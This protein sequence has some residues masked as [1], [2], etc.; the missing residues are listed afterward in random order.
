MQNKW[1]VITS[2]IVISF[3]VVFIGFFYYSKESSSL[4]TIQKREIQTIA[5]LKIDQIIHWR[6]EKIGDARVISQSPYFSRGVQTWL[7]HRLDTSLQNQLRRGLR[8]Y[9]AQFGF[10]DIL[11][12]SRKED[13][14]ISLDSSM[15]ELDRETIH[16][17]KEAVKYHDVT[18]SDCYYCPK[19]RKIHYDIIAPIRDVKNQVITVMIFRADPITNLFPLIGSLSIQ[20]RIAE[21][22]IVQR[23]GDSVLF[24]NHRRFGQDDAF[25]FINPSKKSNNDVVEF[26]QTDKGF[27]NGYDYRGVEVIAYLTTVPEMRWILI[28]KVDHAELNHQLFN[29]AAISGVILIIFLLLVGAVFAVYYRTHQK[30]TYK[31]LFQKERELRVYHEEFRTILY[32]VSDGVVTTDLNGRVKIMNHSAAKLTGWNEAEAK[33]KHVNEVFTI[34]REDT[35][36]IVECPITNILQ[37]DT[38]ANPT[39]NQLLLSKDGREIPIIESGAPIRDELGEVE[40]AVL[41][42]HD[43]TLEYRAERRLHQSEEKYRKAFITSPDAININRLEDGMYVSIN[44]GFTDILGYTQ[45]DVIGKTS[46]ELNIWETRDDRTTFVEAL[47]K[48]GVVQNIVARL[49]GKEN[50]IIYGMM[51]ASIVELGEVKHILSI[52]RDITEFKRVEGAMRE[53]EKKYRNM[54]TNNPQPMWIYD[55][56]TLDFLEVNDAAINHYG[57]SKEEFLSMTIADIRP[58]EDVDA[59]TRY[60]KRIAKVQN[61]SGEWFHRKK[62]GK[63]IS[64]EVVSHSITYRAR[65]ARH[66]IINDITERKQTENALHVSEERFRSLVEIAPLGIAVYQEG[67][68]VY[69]NPAGVKMFG[70]AHKQNLLG[71]PIL[72]FVHP[73]DLETVIKRMGLIAGGLV[74]D[75]VEEKFVRLDGSPFDAEVVALATTFND[76]P[77]GQVIVRD[78]TE[79]KR[80]EEEILMFKLGIERSTD[81]IFITNSEGAITY[82]NKSFENVYGYTQ[83]EIVGRTPRII[84]SGILTL[85]IYQRFWSTLM[86][87]GIVAGEIIN[88]TKDGRLLTIDG[89]NN[90][91]MDATG[92]IVG[93]LGV[94]R[95]ISERKRAENALR[96]SEE[97]LRQIADNVNEVFWIVDLHTQTF[98]FVNKAFESIWGI[99][100]EGL[101]HDPYIW[102]KVIHPLDRH[103]VRNFVSGDS[104]VNNEFRII[105]PDASVRWIHTKSFPVYDEK[106][107]IFRIAGIASD[108]TEIKNASDQLEQQ[109]LKLA[110]VEKM[111]SLGRVVAGV[112]HEINNPNNAISLSTALLHQMVNTI[113]PLVDEFRK[114]HG[115]FQIGFLDY[116]EYRTHVDKLFK[117]IEDGSRQIKKIVNDLKDYARHEALLEDTIVDVHQSINGAITLMD[118]MI[119]EKTRSFTQN[120]ADAQLLILGQPHRLDQVFINL[121]HNACDA[122]TDPEQGITITTELCGADQLKVCV[123]DQG[124]GISSEDLA[125]VT[126]PFFSTKLDSGGTGLGLS[127]TAGIVKDFAGEMFIESELGKGSTF[128][129]V[130]PRYNH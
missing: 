75:S 57:Y 4:H 34:I 28:T 109:K 5:L 26:V 99:P 118:Y 53:S 25:L 9:K 104:P 32:S 130:F 91:I 67:R 123:S 21:T 10:Q 106:G 127:V 2:A 38:V 58:N 60:V 111:S 51:S 112:A 48:K 108:I 74:V 46:T 7:H 70:A 6:N 105:R 40:G 52:T 97:K 77:A 24:L 126:D 44:T 43:K 45:E 64:V 103:L 8:L 30:N 12:L 83:D 92:N 119:K 49:R 116:T 100:V 16:H 63:I 15:A 124:C 84:K 14:L 69:V 86:S 121:L 114:E 110:Q 56:G 1:I 80:V 61:Y 82:A 81:A 125:R 68:V 79:R 76:K 47:V 89:S 22:E 17:V 90:P 62:N 129:L 95:D 72:S 94:H 35:R 73:D 113:L 107:K 23:E 27:V 20:S 102:K 65:K 117:S 122:L 42:Y 3:L 96:E 29:S 88:K 18:M 85:E 115:D 71:K 36:A 55:V 50:K 59:L 11:V 120:L 98:S 93:F 37:E 54:F 39:H 87:G 33:G 101:L 41:I 128:T 31:L 19:H 66:V 78:I 13:L